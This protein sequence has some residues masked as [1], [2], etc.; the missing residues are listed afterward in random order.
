MS[1]SL[2]KR[3]LVFTK[4]Q[5]K[6][7]MCC[8]AH[9][10]ALRSTKGLSTTLRIISALLIIHRHTKLG[11]RRL[12]IL[13]QPNN[14][15]NSRMPLVFEVRVQ[16]PITCPAITVE[17]QAT[18]QGTGCIQGSTT[19]IIQELPYRNNSSLRVRIII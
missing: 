11:R 9:Q 17:S 16:Y 2:Q 7:S 3:S 18:S 1:L 6:R 13:P 12:F 5:R 14:I 8:P 10:V 19:P 4:S 15:H